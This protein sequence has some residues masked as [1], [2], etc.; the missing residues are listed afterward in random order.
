MKLCLEIGAV[1]AGIWLMFKPPAVKLERK[2][3]VVYRCCDYVLI[4]F[5]TTNR[6]WELIE[7]RGDVIYWW[8]SQ[9]VKQGFVP[10]G[11]AATNYYKTNRLW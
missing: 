1:I 4:D 5:Y 7:Q 11:G 10:P 2:F 6:T 3:H 9:G 8:D